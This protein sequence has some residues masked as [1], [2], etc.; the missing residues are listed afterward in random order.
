ML[1]ESLS[2]RPASSVAV[3]VTLAVAAPFPVTD[4]VLAVFG[5]W[6]PVQA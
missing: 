1:A 3:Q 2:V 5:K 6:V 4:R